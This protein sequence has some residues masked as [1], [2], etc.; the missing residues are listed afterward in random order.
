MYKNRDQVGVTLIE[1]LIA[2]ATLSLLSAMA[3]ASYRQYTLRANRTEAT[4]TLLKIQVEQE[5][6][7]LR[8]NRYA[9]TLAEVV[10]APPA[11]LG[12]TLAAGNTTRNGTYTISLPAATA[13]KYQAR[14]DSA[15][16]QSQDSRCTYFAID[17]TGHREPD[18][19]TRCWR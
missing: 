10:A 9:T 16:A 7:F 17:Q 14:A 4:T 5:K 13:T 18:P 12:I 11:G 3:V 1:L 15:G 19:G 6:F 2:M 8:N